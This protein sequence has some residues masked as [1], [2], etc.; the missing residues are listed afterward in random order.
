MDP[1]IPLH[2]PWPLPG[3]FGTWKPKLEPTMGGTPP[4]NY[5]SPSTNIPKMM[6]ARLQVSFSGDM[7]TFGGNY[8]YIYDEI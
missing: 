6:V 3:S 5:H 7:S 2:R 1:V 8:I 4:E